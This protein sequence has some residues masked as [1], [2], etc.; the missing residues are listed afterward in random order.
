VCF[1]LG[2][3][4]MESSGGSGA[5]D[6]IEAARYWTL[7]ADLGHTPSLWNLGIFHM[8]GFGNLPLLIA[9]NMQMNEL[10]TYMNHKVFQRLIY[11]R[12]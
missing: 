7:A 3:I 1:Q 6:P 2:L 4:A 12:E 5:P 11:H 10:K 8:N 9:L